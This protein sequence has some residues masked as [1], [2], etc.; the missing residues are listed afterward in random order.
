META[1]IS[2]LTEGEDDNQLISSIQG[3]GSGQ[4]MSE[5]AGCPCDCGSLAVFAD[6]VDFFAITNSRY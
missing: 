3:I 4:G 1:C 5:D 2:L 6:V